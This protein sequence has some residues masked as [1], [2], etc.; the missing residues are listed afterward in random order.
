MKTIHTQTPSVQDIAD[1]LYN[2]MYMDMGRCTGEKIG[3]RSTCLQETNP[4]FA[5]TEFPN[6]KSVV[7]LRAFTESNADKLLLLLLLRMPFSHMLAD[8][9]IRLP[10]HCLTPH[11]AANLPNAD[12]CE[13]CM[14][15]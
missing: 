1:S 11:V 4:T 8:C 5:A 10:E 12:S 15:G 13:A 6:R 14:A 2:D 7:K 3:P 9:E